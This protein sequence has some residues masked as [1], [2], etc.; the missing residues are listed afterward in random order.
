MKQFCILILALFVVMLSSCIDGDE[1]IFLHADGSARMIAIY[2]LPAMIFSDEDAAKLQQQIAEGIG[3]EKKVRLLTNKIERINGKQVITIEVETADLMELGDL[4][5]QEPDQKK[6][7]KSGQ[8][9]DA[10]LGDFIFRREGLAVGVNRKVDLA[11]LLDQ[12]VG[13]QWPSMLGDSEFRYTIHFPKAVKESNA[14]AVSN[15]GKTV[16][17]VY[18]LGECKKTPIELDMVAPIPLPWW[19]Y[20]GLGLVVLLLLW[21]IVKLL[22][23]KKKA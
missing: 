19:V 11:P 23:R 5:G 3:G 12:F 14:H 2:S 1:E 18:Q 8:V 15:G 9:L 7:E 13:E 17:W 10:L 21:V 16:K 20:A 6:E 4:M 22:C